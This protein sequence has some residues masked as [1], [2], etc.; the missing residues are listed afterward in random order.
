MIIMLLKCVLPDPYCLI[1]W[2]NPTSELKWLYTG[3]EILGKIDLSRPYILRI[4]NS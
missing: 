3:I 4:C 2:D 1:R